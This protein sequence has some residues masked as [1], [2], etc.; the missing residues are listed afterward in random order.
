MFCYQTIQLLA[1]IEEQEIQKLMAAVID[2]QLKKLEAKLEHFVQLEQMLERE[3]LQVPT[4][5]FF[6]CFSCMMS[7]YIA[8]SSLRMKDRNSLQRRWPLCEKSLVC[9][10]QDLRQHVLY[11]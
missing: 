9:N 5:N 4:N 10:R 6:L 3:K 7:N 2:T 1:E 8:S 11:K